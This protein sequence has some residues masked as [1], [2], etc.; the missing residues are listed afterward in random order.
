MATRRGKALLG[1]GIPLLVL[2]LLIA[3]WA[4]DT[5]GT[6]GKVP[7]N[8]RLAGRDIGRMPEE[9]LAATVRSINKQY[10]ATEVEVSTPARSYKISAGKLGLTLDEDATVQAA[11]DIGRHDSLAMR[12]IAWLGSFLQHR[13]AKL[14][15]RVRRDVM[16]SGLASLEGQRRV[17]KEPSL[18][19]TSNAVDIIS[20]STGSAIDPGNVAADLVKR[21]SSGELPIVVQTG[22]IER[23]PKVSDA[24]ARSIA[25]KLT[26]KTAKPL[27]VKAGRQTVTF[28]PAITRSWLDSK[29]GATGLEVTV[30]GKKVMAD[31]KAGLTQV[32]KARNASFQVNG[33]T[34][35]ITPSRNGTR[36]C[37][38]G[39]SARLLAAI[40]SGTGRAT[41]R[42]A[43]DKPSFTTEAA[44][45][46]GIKEP[47]G[48]TTDWK[49]QP[50]VKSFT[51]YY[52]GGAPRVI[53]IHLIADAVRGAIIKPGATFSLDGR[54]GERTAK[55]GYVEAPEIKNRVDV[56]GVGGGVSQFSTTL[57]NAAFFAGLDIVE[58]QAHSLYLDRY[59]YGREATLG[60]PV[61]DQKIK[62]N[63]PYGILIWT[64]YTD[65]SVTVTMYSTQYAYGEQ[66]DQKTRPVGPCTGVK[67]T[68]T[69]HYPDGHTS[70]D[71]FSAVY[72]PAEGV[73][74]G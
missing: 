55:K 65:T 73:K 40:R 52:P 74:C 15:F 60:W 67:T 24:Q 51:T 41:I 5:G 6:S 37:A 44:K 28:Q 71:T 62:N 39:S 3:A 25:S 27:V 21:A 30:D 45:K 17:P 26:T 64:S 9:E 31:L 10:Q 32:T 4:I 63:T 38:A 68:R 20:G 29:I 54:V 18:V 57:F 7:R 34:V 49:G 1:I 58:Y 50:Q 22:L 12:P 14:K 23:K 2:V 36:C 8:V 42:L 69:R 72:R 66:T 56:T 61:P 70:T 48:T 35:A 33:P 53:N 13:T 47:V 16:A 59:P 11:L 46:L 19:A 43:V